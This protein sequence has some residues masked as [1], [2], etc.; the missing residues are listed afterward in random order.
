MFAHSEIG[1][2]LEFLNMVFFV[3]KKIIYQTVLQAYVQ[4]FNRKNYFLKTAHG[5]DKK[6]E[7][8]KAFLS[9]NN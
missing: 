7:A 6:L 9:K 5:V 4:I 2:I 8:E 1:L 3:V